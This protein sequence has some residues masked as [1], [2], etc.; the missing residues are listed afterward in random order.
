[1]VIV[2]IN[3]IRRAQAQPLYYSKR[4]FIFIRFVLQDNGHIFVQAANLFD[5]DTRGRGGAVH[6]AYK[7]IPALF[8][9]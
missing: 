1:L 2:Q 9:E 5:S 8:L 7:Q 6:I 3:H 4:A